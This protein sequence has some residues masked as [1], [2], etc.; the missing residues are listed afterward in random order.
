LSCVLYQMSQHHHNLRIPPAYL[1]VTKK[2][3][4]FSHHCLAGNHKKKL[5]ILF[6]AFSKESQKFGYIICAVFSSP[7][8]PPTFVCTKNY[9][10]H[11][12]YSNIY[13]S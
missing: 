13:G 4:L 12:Y 10:T 9:Y 3:S 2:Y 1:R 7:G 6:I 8:C 11:I 5:W